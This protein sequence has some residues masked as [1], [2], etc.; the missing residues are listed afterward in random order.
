MTHRATVVYFINIL[1]NTLQHET[2]FPAQSGSLL[3]VHHPE[4]QGFE[5]RQE[6]RRCYR[7]GLWPKR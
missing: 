6:P 3:T 4:L 5:V 7:K 2:S 1:I